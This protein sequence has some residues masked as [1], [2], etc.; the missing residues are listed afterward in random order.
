MTIQVQTRPQRPGS[1]PVAGPMSMDME[2]PDSAGHCPRS[3][4][5]RALPRVGALVCANVGGE[6]A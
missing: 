1:S 6:R 5:A 2:M 3:T 4:P